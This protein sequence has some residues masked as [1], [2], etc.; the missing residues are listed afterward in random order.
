MSAP[1]R[2]WTYG[3][4]NADPQDDDLDHWRQDEWWRETTHDDGGAI[5][6]LVVALPVAALMWLVMAAAVWFIFAIMSFTTRPA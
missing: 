2:S 1:A 6:G 5:R 3:Y 4:S